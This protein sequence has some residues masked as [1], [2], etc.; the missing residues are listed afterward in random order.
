MIQAKE[1]ANYQCEYPNCSW[2]PFLDSSNKNYI[3]THHIIPLA[4][5]GPDILENCIALCPGCHR[6]AHYSSP[7]EQEK[8][9]KI[10]KRIRGLSHS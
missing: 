9:R 10:F 2:I 5:G 8:M 6:Q 1:R 3:E 7:E 4:M